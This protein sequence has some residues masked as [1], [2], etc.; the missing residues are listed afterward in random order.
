MNQHAPS[1]SSIKLPEVLQPVQPIFYKSEDKERKIREYALI[2]ID[3]L[4]KENN[5]DLTKAEEI[6]N[7]ESC[8]PLELYD[9]TEFDD[10]LNPKVK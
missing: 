7:I 8:L 1:L 10:F 5:I 6:V 4:L 2:N 3:E 9:D